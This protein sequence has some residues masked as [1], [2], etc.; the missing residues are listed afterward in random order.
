MSNRTRTRA[1]SKA[2]EAHPA[3]SPDRPTI[4]FRVDPRGHAGNRA[5]RA[6]L[7][8]ER[9]SLHPTA[10][11]HNGHRA[12]AEHR[13]LI[14]QRLA[15]NRVTRV[16]VRRA[17]AESLGIT[18]VDHFNAQFRDDLQGMTFKEK[19]ELF[20]HIRDLDRPCDREE[21]KKLI[22][23]H[24]SQSQLPTAPTP[25]EEQ[26]GVEPTPSTTG[27]PPTKEQIGVEPTP[28]TTGSPPTK[29]QI[30]VVPTPP[31]LATPVLSF[32]AKVPTLEATLEQT[33]D[34]NDDKKEVVLAALEKTYGSDLIAATKD[35]AVVKAILKFINA[36]QTTTWQEG[37]RVE[38]PGSKDVGKLEDAENWT[39]RHYTDKY[40]WDAENRQVKPPSFKE[41][42][43]S[44]TLAAMAR[45]EEESS[46]GSEKGKKGAG[47]SGH[48]SKYDWDIIGNVGDTFY[49]LF[50]KGK[51]AGQH[52]T[53]LD[54]AQ[55]YAEWKI[56]DCTEIWAS[57]DW[58]TTAKKK[59]AAPRGPAYEG[60]PEDVV[61]AFLGRFGRRG[62]ESSQRKIFEGGFDNF[63]VKLHGPL[64]LSA[65]SVNKDWMRVPGAKQTPEE[66]AL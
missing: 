21:V 10:G 26:I 57:S 5:T 29:E 33:W 25:T 14:L 11:R 40:R 9:H 36:R 19:R 49:G 41:I 52:Q 61:S 8:N 48:T 4:E 66:K 6:M 58:L 63:E 12:Q 39:L 28:S 23:E 13:I 7:S 54:D 51:L 65:S 22:G 46:G 30:G 31:T 34:T 37:T 18:T 15:G 60:K 43:S 1:T 17:F 44:L 53:F 38:P 24:R 42:L 55:W 16:V 2:P 59:G 47:K 45:G 64:A 62:D 27:S 35:R 20:Q 50:Y 32:P 56:T 3:R